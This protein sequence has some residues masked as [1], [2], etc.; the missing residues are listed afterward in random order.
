MLPEVEAWLRGHTSS[1]DDW[2]MPW[3]L[4]AKGDT[5]VSVV[6]PARDEAETVGE[7]V[8]A[9]RRDLMESVP[10]VDELVVIDSRSVDD[11]AVRAARAGARVIAQDDI[12]PDLKPMDG[13]GEALWKSLAAT[14]GDLLVFIDAD[15]REFRTSFVTGLLGPLFAG[16]GVAY[17]KGCYDRPLQ[18][19]QSGGG[20]VTELV[21]RPLLNLHWPLLAGFV[22]P[23]AGEYAGRRSALERVPFVTGYGV[24]LGLLIDLLDLAGLDALAQVDLGRRVHSHQSTEALGGMASQILQTSWSRLERQNMM[25]SLHTPSLRLAQFR[26]GATGHHATVRDVAVAERPPMITIPGYSAA[27]GR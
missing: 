7:I 5:T 14:S 9:I 10:L 6:L 19:V 26:R 22:Q 17:V 23:L 8:T 27:P 25:V 3:L 13:K 11:T 12:L 4:E 21:A 24:E 15:L 20:R 2:S 18:N 16:P 1:S